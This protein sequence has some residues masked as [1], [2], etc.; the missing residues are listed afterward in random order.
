MVISISLTVMRDML[1]SG[2]LDDVVV[3]E[4]DKYNLIIHAYDINSN[5]N[6]VCDISIVAIDELTPEKIQFVL[7]T[8][9]IK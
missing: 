3:N 7:D 4:E 6:S 2:V 5:Y 8:I 1:F 9:E